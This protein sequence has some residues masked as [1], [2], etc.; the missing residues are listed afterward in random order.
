MVKNPISGGDRSPFLEGGSTPMH[1]K[2][3]T[4]TQ[5]PGVSSQ[6]GSGALSGGAGDPQAGAPGAGYYASG[7]TNKDYAGTQSPGTSGPTKS[8]GDAKFASGGT[9]PMFGNRGSLPARG[10]RMQ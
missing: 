4:A 9:T 10:G 5:K 7:T 2:T 3:G 1:G 8:G 6:E